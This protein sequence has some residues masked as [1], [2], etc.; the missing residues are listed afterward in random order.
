MSERVILFLCTLL[1]YAIAPVKAQNY[2]N[3][4]GKKFPVVA[5]YSVEPGYITRSEY[6]MMSKAGFTLSLSSF[7][8][9]EETIKALSVAKGTGVK[10]IVDC[11]DARN[12]ATPFINNVKNSKAL[13]LYYLSDEPSSDYFQNLQEKV[14][15]IKINDNSHY[16]YINLLPLYASSEQTNTS[17]Y[18]DYLERYIEM[19]EPDYISYDHYPF[20]RDEYRLD[21]FDNL[22]IVSKVCKK[23]NIVFWGFVRSLYD[24]NYT[25]ID[26]GRIR[27]QVFS[28]LAYGAQAIQYFTYSSPRGCGYAIVDSLHNKTPLYDIVSAINH[29][30]QGYSKFFLNSNVLS[31]VHSDKQGQEGNKISNVISHLDS[32]GVGVLL[33]LFEKKGKYYLIVVNKDYENSQEVTIEFN[34]KAKVISQKGR[35][36]TSSYHRFVLEAGNGMLFHLKIKDLYAN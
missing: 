25:K 26:E 13:G 15:R 12:A 24:S 14:Q 7:L 32:N 18:K 16:P 1:L 3:P 20:V 22:D 36:K 23:H 30:I 34:K 27:F 21:F 33:S 31:I 2:I 8:S 4:V 11:Q 28:Q 19:M 17:S 29:E 6:K 10:L 9:K 35:A 5:W